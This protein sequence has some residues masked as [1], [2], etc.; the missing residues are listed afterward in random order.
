MSNFIEKAKDQYFA[1]METYRSF[2]DVFTSI[3]KLARIK[4]YFQTNLWNIEEILSILEM[5]TY[6]DKTMSRSLF[7]K[8]IADV[9]TYCTKPKFRPVDVIHTPDDLLGP[10]PWRQYV[11]FVA[12]L[13]NCPPL[14]NTAGVFDLVDSYGIEHPETEYSII[15]LNYDLVLELIAERISRL[16]RKQLIFSRRLD[17]P[18]GTFRYVRLAKLHGSIDTDDIIPPTWNKAIQNN[19]PSADWQLAYELLKQA[20]HICVLGYSLPETDTYVKYLLRAGILH[21]QNLKSI[22]VLCLD[23]EES[24]IK[25][26]Y[27]DFVTFP[28]YHFLSRNVVDFLRAILEVGWTVNADIVEYHSPMDVIPT[29][30]LK[31]KRFA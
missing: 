19:G 24:S 7:R 3:D 20:N 6:L 5:E 26:R 17:D 4:N 12:S 13:M 16:T 28:N 21:A 25:R 18:Q 27:D 2:A 31:R 15:T 9:I 22:S 8:F 30:I 11:I 14:R 1:D 29:A 10:D 23:D